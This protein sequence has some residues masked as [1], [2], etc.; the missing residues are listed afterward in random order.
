[1]ATSDGQSG[2]MVAVIDNG[3]PSVIMQNQING[4]G[5]SVVDNQVQINN[6]DAVF[7]NA[8]DLI[9]NGKTG[10]TGSFSNVTGF[11]VQNGIVYSVTGQREA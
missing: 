10:L 1:M 4:T 11:K 6:A 7:I 2:P 3:T 8:N 9:I 5:V